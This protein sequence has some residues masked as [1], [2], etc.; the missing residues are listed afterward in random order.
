MRADWP[1]RILERNRYVEDG[2]KPLPD[3]E[4]VV[5]CGLQ[6]PTPAPSRAQS[7]LMPPPQSRHGLYRQ[8][9]QVLCEEG[10]PWQIAIDRVLP[11]LVTAPEG[12]SV[13]SDRSGVLLYRS[14][15]TRRCLR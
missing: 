13:F 14:R 4:N 6:I 1:I 2:L 12:R 7:P 3:I 8:R 11:P 9:Q 10:R 15:D 5:S